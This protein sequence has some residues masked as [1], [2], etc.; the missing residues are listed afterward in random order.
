VGAL[1]ALAL[2]TGCATMFEHRSKAVSLQSIPDGAEWELTRE[3]DS[4]PIEVG[5]TPATLRL[6]RGNGYFQPAHYSVH[7]HKE[8]FEP[9]T[10]VFQT[11]IAGNY[12]FNL[13]WLPVITLWP[14]ISMLIVDPLTGAM[15]DPEVPRAVVL[16][17]QSVVPPNE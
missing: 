12:W 17:K 3:G 1:G 9:E 11:S 8:G 7:V 13:L 5:V 4:S 14:P 16:R 6:V 10:V 2:A 15:W